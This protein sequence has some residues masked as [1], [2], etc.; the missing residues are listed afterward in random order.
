MIY[1][2]LL[3]LIIFIICL[4]YSIYNFIICKKDIVEKFY[5]E[6][7]DNIETLFALCAKKYNDNEIKKLKY[8]QS[9]RGEDFPDKRL[10]TMA[11][12]KNTPELKKYC[13]P[14]WT[15]VSWP[16][17]NIKSFETM[18]KEISKSGDKESTV[19]K[20][21]WYGSTTSPQ[22]HVVEY[23]TRPLLKKIGDENPDD[24]DII[25]IRPVKYQIN[26]KVI[27]NYISLPD[28][29]KYKY[30]L[31]IGGNG[32]SGR[33][34]YL[35]YSKRPILLI[36]RNYVEYFHDDLKPYEHYIPVEMDLSDLLDQVEWMK[37]NPDKCKEI[38]QNAYNFAIENF[39]KE[40]L[41][42]RIYEVYKNLSED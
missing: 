40:K 23:K 26:E 39:T 12:N 17:A 25:D 16:S 10:Y 36:D 41:I 14:D 42:D 35:L 13:G 8:D 29:T 34:K 19:N 11:Y 4:C 37:Q 20:V 31:D 6:R 1:Y 5:N 27:N 38:A 22:S 28:L 3:L 7:N 9:D 30:L 33:L 21:G 24:F 15:F 2:I 32:Y 18:I